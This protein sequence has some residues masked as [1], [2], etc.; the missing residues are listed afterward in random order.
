MAGFSYVGLSSTEE[1][2]S[3]NMALAEGFVALGTLLGGLISGPIIDKF[4]IEIMIYILIGVSV[5]RIVLTL[6]I[7]EVPKPLADR[8]QLKEA[9]SFRRVVDMFKC[10]FKR[11]S[12][13]SRL[14]LHLTFMAYCGIYCGIAGPASVNFLYLVKEIGLTMTQYSVVLGV[15]GA[16]RSLLGPLIMFCVKRLKIHEITAAQVVTAVCAF[17]SI[18]F[19]LGPSLYY[20]WIGSIL[21]TLLLVPMAVIRSLQIKLIGKDDVGKLFAYASI[22]QVILDAVVV[23]ILNRLY[24]LTLL[25]WPQ[26]YS[27]VTALF[28]IFTL[29][30]MLL[31]Y[32]TIRKFNPGL[33]M[34]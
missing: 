3:V 23:T 4:G 16:L 31:M 28:Y 14:T 26:F 11:R 25:I 29:V 27:A 21:M 18:I 33:D 20:I 8:V 12:N 5:L 22:L 19:S 13:H 24:S 2:Q 15:T 9:L 34:M 1:T 17:G 10:I 30:I 32:R 6:F 7:K